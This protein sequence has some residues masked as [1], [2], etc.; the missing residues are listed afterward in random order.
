MHTHTHT[1]THRLG[2]WSQGVLLAESP[3]ITVP[4]PTPSAGHKTA[5]KKGSEKPVAWAAETSL[6]V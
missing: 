3:E 4:S 5:N 6:S 1:H 2:M